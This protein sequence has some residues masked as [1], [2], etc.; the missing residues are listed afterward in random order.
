[1]TEPVALSDEEIAEVRDS[2][3]HDCHER[4]CGGHTL[5]HT[6]GRRAL[7]TIDK[8]RSER[9]ERPSVDVKKVALAIG[10]R[11]LAWR[12]GAD[13]HMTQDSVI[14]EELHRQLGGQE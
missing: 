9:D 7:A 3:A 2:T 6:L 8:L 11:L 14:A 5:I 1:M 10:W 13:P 4:T 12:N